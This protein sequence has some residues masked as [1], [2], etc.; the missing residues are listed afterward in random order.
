MYFSGMEKRLQLLGEILLV[1]GMGTDSAVVLITGAACLLSGM[2]CELRSI[3]Q[4][5][6]A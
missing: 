5:K 1:I 6:A 2:G 4:K 3:T